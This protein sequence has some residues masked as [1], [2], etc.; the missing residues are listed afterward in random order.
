MLQLL[1]DAVFA[2]HPP[3]D[4]GRESLQNR[5]A[6][7]VKK[8]SKIFLKHVLVVHWKLQLAFSTHEINESLQTLSN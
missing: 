5:Y 2:G 3:G 4:V 6:S 7:H 8:H 1:P